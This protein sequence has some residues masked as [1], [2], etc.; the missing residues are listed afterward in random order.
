LNF[1]AHATVRRDL[2]GASPQLQ[3]ANERYVRGLADELSRD[4]KRLFGDMGAFGPSAHSLFVTVGI[5][6]LAEG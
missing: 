1:T 2:P 4:L 5:P 3:H 6:G